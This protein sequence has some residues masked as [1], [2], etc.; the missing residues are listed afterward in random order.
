MAETIATSLLDRVRLQD[1][2]AWRRL[3]QLFTPLVYKWAR[4]AGLSEH[5]AADLVQEVFVGVMSS[6]AQ[7]RR[8]HDGATFRGWLRRI[9]QFKIIDFQRNRLGR[10][11]A[12]G[13]T[14]ANLRLQQQA[15]P[16]PEDEE[17]SA[18]EAL[19][20]RGLELI[21]GE[22]EPRSWQAFQAVALDDRPP[23]DVATELNMSVRRRLHRQESSS[24]TL[25]RRARRPH[26]KARQQGN[27]GRGRDETPH[28]VSPWNGK[29]SSQSL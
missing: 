4:Q 9:T 26:L 22:F 29:R 18:S 28:D 12:E 11:V 1:E 14:D 10:P 13:G 7:F 24:Q 3:M 15:G 2:E 19:V 27:Q 23:G 17:A 20:R 5:D 25:A 6:V 16:L 8:D 21:R